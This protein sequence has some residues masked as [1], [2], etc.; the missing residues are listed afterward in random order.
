MESEIAGADRTAPWS[1]AIA[2][3]GKDVENRTRPLEAPMT[4]IG[5]DELI[6]ARARHLRFGTEA[7]AEKLLDEVI[8]TGKGQ[9]AY[10]VANQDVFRRMIVAAA[11]RRGMQVNTLLDYWGFWS[12]GVHRAEDETGRAVTRQARSF[13]RYLASSPANDPAAKQRQRE[14]G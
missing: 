8:A 3:G 10:R 13:Q 14:T 12:V 11:R 5:R 1:W 7:W 6:A 4:D 2:H 9:I